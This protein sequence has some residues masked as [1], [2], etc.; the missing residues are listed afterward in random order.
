MAE[1][2]LGE[3]LTRLVTL[4]SLFLIQHVPQIMSICV[5]AMSIT[6][7]VCH[8]EAQ[9]LTLRHEKKTDEIV[10]NLFKLVLVFIF[11]CRLRL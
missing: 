2:V 9:D 1:T 7:I 3:T 6:A 10:F 11:R 8:L 5:A 4:S